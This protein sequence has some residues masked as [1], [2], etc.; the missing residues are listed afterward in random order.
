V[1]DRSVGIAGYGWRIG[2]SGTSFYLKPMLKSLAGLKISLHGPDPR[3]SGAV[4]LFGLDESAG[5][6][7][8]NGGVWIGSSGR[9]S[10]NGA[11]LEGTDAV[12]A[13]K[14]RSRS[15]LFEKGSISG[16]IPRPLK[17]KQVGGALP[18]PQPFYAT[19]LDVFISNGA[20]YWP[21][22]EQARRDNACMGPLR[23][24]ADQYLSAVCTRTSLIKSPTPRSEFVV[25][26]DEERIRAIR[27][28]VDEDHDFL[29]VIED[30]LPRSALE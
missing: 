11:R 14:F 17:S 19:D 8:D 25:A 4:F 3:H 22:E 10:F 28:M 15:G 9:H 29:W 1:A 26:A 30:W 18:P 21:K 12:L 5:S 20:P 6:P 23:N 2:W 24:R 13:V 16:P 7:V 27:A